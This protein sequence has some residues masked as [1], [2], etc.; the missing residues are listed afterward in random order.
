MLDTKTNRRAYGDEHLSLLF[1]FAA[2]EI[3]QG[4]RTLK[5]SLQ[6]TSEIQMYKYNQMRTEVNRWS[7]ISQAI[8]NVRLNLLCIQ[9]G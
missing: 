3:S 8:G 1:A 9:A 5:M 7:Y 6:Y 2:E 4:C